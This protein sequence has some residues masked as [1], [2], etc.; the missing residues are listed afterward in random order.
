MADNS[1]MK[2]LLALVIVF[3]PL[4]AEAK[5]YDCRGLANNIADL[6]KQWHTPNL[7][8]ERVKE[9]NRILDNAY[10]EYY[11][12]ANCSESELKDAFGAVYYSPRSK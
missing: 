11:R 10:N 5:T 7:P 4:V 9:L 12:I 8:E 6:E 2:Y 3:S 1:A